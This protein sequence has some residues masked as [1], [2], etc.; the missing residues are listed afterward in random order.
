MNGLVKF[1]PDGY[2][3]MER[4]IKKNRPE[5]EITGAHHNDL[6][7]T[8]RMKVYVCLTCRETKCD[9]SDDCVRRHMRVRAAELEKLKNS[10]RIMTKVKL[11]CWRYHHGQN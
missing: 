3:R 6:T 7:V 4:P 9:G 2:V 5:C 8:D 10:G 11:N 1:D